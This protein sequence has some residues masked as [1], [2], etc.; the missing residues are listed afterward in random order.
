[1]RRRHGH[2]RRLL[3]HLRR[4]HGEVLQL[5]VVFDGHPQ[6]ALELFD[7]LRGVVAQVEVESKVLKRF[8]IFN[9]QA[10]ESKQGQ[11]GVNM[12]RPTEAEAAAASVAAAAE[13]TG[14]GA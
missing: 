8:L 11:P 13:C 10:L 9:L 1:M 2:G 6:P 12:H 5:P 3:Q 14:A 7:E 4:L